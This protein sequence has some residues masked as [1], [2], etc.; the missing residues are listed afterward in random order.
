MRVFVTGGAGFIGSHLA[1]R[2]VARGDDVVLLDNLQTGRRENIAHLIEPGA[3][4][5][6]EG[7]VLDRGLVREL[8]SGADVVVHLASAVGV[9][10]VIERPLE[11]LLG[12][13]RGAD[14]VSEAATE[15]GA[16]LLFASTSEIYGKVSDDCLN[17]HSDRIVG[18][19][20]TAR[21]GYATAKVFGEMLAYGYHR[22]GGAE[23]IVVRFFNTV[24]PRQTG[25]Y[26]MVI[27]RLVGQ[28]L[29]DE[30]LTVYGDGRQTRCFGHVADAI[31]AVTGLLDG[32]PEL[33]GRPFNVGNRNNEISIADLAQR[34]IDR[35]GSRSKI[36]LVP[37]DEVFGDGF[38]ELGKRK[39]DTSALR[40]AIG[41]EP[42]RDIDTVIDDVVRH[43]AVMRDSLP[44]R[45]YGSRTRDR[46]PSRELTDE[47]S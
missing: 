34:I 17:E 8:C 15:A 22:S 26:G 37:Y 30:N 3:V 7:S 20:Q 12:N 33:C 41:W 24:G 45:L 31:D 40:N 1:D 11:S 27:P 9:R 42:T 35:T 2:L 28:A 38:E 4:E 43:L 25:T 16:R 18:S 21:W 32:G 19:P 44:S 5:F 23:T 39:P 13:V 6:V 29:I 36:R 10:L 47:A 14:I 46:E